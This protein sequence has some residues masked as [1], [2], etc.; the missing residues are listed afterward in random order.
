MFTI[1]VRAYELY[2]IPHASGEGAADLLKS[3]RFGFLMYTRVGLFT[4]I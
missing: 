2:L 1:Y 4:L 3:A